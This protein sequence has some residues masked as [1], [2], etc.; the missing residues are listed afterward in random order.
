MEYK[1]FINSVYKLRL[2]DFLY[3]IH[4]ALFH[5]FVIGFLTVVSTKTKAARRYYTLCTC[6]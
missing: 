5:L 1:Y 6:I 3:F 2:E 4:N